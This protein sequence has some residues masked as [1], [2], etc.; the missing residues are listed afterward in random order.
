[1]PIRNGTT[2]PATYALVWLTSPEQVDLDV[3][4]LPGL[5]AAVE[6]GEDA[7]RRVQ[8]GHDVEDGDAR[9]VRLAVG[10]AG[11]AHQA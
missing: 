5:V 2:P 8:A 10:V 9:P 7:D 3:L 6:R 1:L 4:P 11:E